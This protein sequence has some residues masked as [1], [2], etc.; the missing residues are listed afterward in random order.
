MRGAESSTEKAAPVC[1]TRA[2]GTPSR[3]RIGPTDR[4]LGARAPSFRFAFRSL[5]PKGVLTDIVYWIVDQSR[6]DPWRRRA[7]ERHAPPHNRCW[8]LDE[9]RQHRQRS[10]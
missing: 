2:E 10:V 5:V 4:G 1:T 3:T 9:P 8:I 7:V 6:P